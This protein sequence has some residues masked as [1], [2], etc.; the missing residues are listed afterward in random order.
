MAI[1]ADSHKI[2]DGIEDEREDEKEDEKRKWA[3]SHRKKRLGHKTDVKQN[4]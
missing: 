3:R 1:Y 2:D 4:Q